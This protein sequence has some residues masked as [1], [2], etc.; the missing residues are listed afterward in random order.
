V[1]RVNLATRQGTAC[2]GRWLSRA[3]I[4]FGGAAAGTALAWAISASTASADQLT[5]VTDTAAMATRQLSQVVPDVVGH[6]VD[7]SARLATPGHRDGDREHHHRLD[8]EVRHAV[9]DLARDTVLDPAENLLGS[10]ARITGQ[11]PEIPRVIDTALAPP[12]DLLGL[13]RS[14]SG[15]L[16]KLPAVQLGDQRE[17]GGQRENDTVSLDP[18]ESQPAA[19]AVSMASVAPVPFTPVSVIPHNASRIHHE[20]RPGVLPVSLP[21]PAP[22]APPAPAGL[23]LIPGGTTAGGHG[24]GPLFGVPVSTQFAAAADAPRAIRFGVRHLPV[25]PGSQPGVTPD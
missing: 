1:T 7:R 8:S 12:K 21:N 23:P 14:G 16:V 9:R 22:Q 15:Q 3:L 24:D 13:L 5:P 11:R 25:Q 4:V 17:S 6:T 19:T 2:A 20:G 18:A 10:I